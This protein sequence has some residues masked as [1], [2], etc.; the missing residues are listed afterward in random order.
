MG[1]RQVSSGNVLM[2]KYC[3]STGFPLGYLL[4][5]QSH[6]SSGLCDF[7]DPNPRQRNHCHN[8]GSGVAKEEVLPGAMLWC[9]CAPIGIPF[10]PA[11]SLDFWT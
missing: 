1:L 11:E 2:E 8:G 3:S 4:W 10:C 5:L 6:W 7:V 9:S